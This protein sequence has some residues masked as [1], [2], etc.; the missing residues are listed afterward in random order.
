MEVNDSALLR[1]LML[2]QRRT[3]R[4]LIFVASFLGL[5]FSAVAITYLYGHWWMRS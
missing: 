1:E 2:H 3:N 4:V 5:L